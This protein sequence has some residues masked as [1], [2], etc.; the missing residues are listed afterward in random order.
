MADYVLEFKHLQKHFGSKEVLT[1]VNFAVSP[2]TIVGYIGPNGAGKSTTVKIILGLLTADG[3]SVEL[4]GQPVSTRDSEY[5]RRIGYVPEG[6]DVFNA[7]SAREYLELVGQLYGMTAELA[8]TRAEQLAGIVGLGDVIDRR[9]VSYSK[10]MRQLVLIIASLIHNP[11]ILFWDESLNGLDANAVL[12]V[13]EILRELRNRGKTIFYS[14]HIMDV[15]Q[16]LS[17]RIVL[18]NAG[19]IVADGPFSELQQEGSNNLQE[20]FNDLTGYAEHGETAREFV[21]VLTGG[22]SDAENPVE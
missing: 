21:D 16:K 12:L 18:L 22:S 5:K 13:E 14:S 1:D 17:D 10:G 20:L 19:Q 8:S 15:V 6:A 2:G 9:I 4:F 11:D 3:G 7:L